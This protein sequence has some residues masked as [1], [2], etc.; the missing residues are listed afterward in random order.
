MAIPFDPVA[1]EATGDPGLAL[2][3]VFSYRWDSS[4][5]SYYAI[6]DEG[7]L[8]YVPGGEVEF[9]QS[10]RLVWVDRN[11]ATR[12]FGED[13]NDHFYPRLHP[14]GGQ[15]A[16]SRQD[17]SGRNIYLYDV[18]RPTVE[19]FTSEGINY[20]S[21]WMPTGEGLIYQRLFSKSLDSVNSEKLPVE[22]NLGWP[23]S[24]SPD[25]R[26]LAYADVLPESSG[27]IWI[28]DLEDPGPPTV[29]ADGPE[30]QRAPWFSPNGRAITY[31]AGSS[32]AGMEVYVAPFPG[33][34]RPIPVSAGGGTEPVW[35]P[36]GELSIG[37]GTSSSRSKSRR[38]PTSALSESR[39]CSR[40]SP[41][42]FLTRM[43]G[44]IRV[45]Q[46]TNCADEAVS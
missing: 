7:T 33:P 4:N 46:L 41:L 10:T 38:L 34:G 20:I 19:R 15:V 14:G 9:R 5:I 23:G 39:P 44:Y 29:F 26:Y 43:Y 13:V 40:T 35:G 37:R 32:F 30:N 6:S 12:P 8:A 22:T 25:G 1:L 11:G 21:A 31:V 36:N 3:G 42:W 45:S 27:D 24:V 16:V 17:D 18:N 28:L 2:E